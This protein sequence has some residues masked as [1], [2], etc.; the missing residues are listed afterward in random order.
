MAEL[1]QLDN[2]TTI[3]VSDSFEHPE[4]YGPYIELLQ[5]NGRMTVRTADI[6]KISYNFWFETLVNFMKDGIEHP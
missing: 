6:N 5:N 2:G 1:I 3:E 4:N